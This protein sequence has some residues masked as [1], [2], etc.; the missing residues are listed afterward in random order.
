VSQ[1]LNE[2][3]VSACILTLGMK[4]FLEL[5]IEHVEKVEINTGS[6]DYL[7]CLLEELRCTLYN[8]NRRYVRNTKE[9]LE[10]KK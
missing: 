1:E 6:Q 2:S 9:A 5:T 7:D 3:Y 4:K 10:P 8:Y